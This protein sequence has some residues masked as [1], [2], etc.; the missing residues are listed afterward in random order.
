MYLRLWKFTFKTS[1]SSMPPVWAWATNFEPNSV[2]S[3]GVSIRAATLPERTDCK[4]CQMLCSSENEGNKHQNGRQWTQHQTGRQW[5]QHH[6][7]DTSWI[8]SSSH[9]LMKTTT[10]TIF[11][12]NCYSS[13]ET[14]QDFAF[15][16]LGDCSK[17]SQHSQFMKTP[18]FF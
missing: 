12:I 4:V 13:T 17:F 9:L 5:T 15:F 6:A 3:I 8:I 2:K 18:G 16:I 1:L 14:N 10:N 7:Q 11:F